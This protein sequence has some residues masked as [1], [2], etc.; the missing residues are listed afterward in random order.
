MD[1]LNP[2][3]IYH[4][5]CGSDSGWSDDHTFKSGIERYSSPFYLVIYGDTRT[6]TI[7]RVVVRNA[8]LK[9]LDSV[10]LILHCGDII[11][12]GAAQWQWNIFFTQM[13]TLFQSCPVMPTIGNHDL[14]D[15]NYLDQFSLPKN[16]GTERYYSFDYGN[17][18]IVSLYIPTPSSRNAWVIDDLTNANNNPAIRWKILFFHVPPYSAG[19]GYQ[20]QR[21]DIPPICDQFDIDVVY[22]GHTHNYE[23]TYLLYDNTVI[24]S[25]PDY[26]GDVD[27][28][29]Y[30]V[31]GGGMQ[32]I[33]GGVDDKGESQP[34]L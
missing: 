25:G 26:N 4:Y 32:S 21:E 7:E 5:R 9:H 18:H 16:S 17:L 12:N 22:C 3:T 11:A 28:T 8:I 29:V 33:P 24:D 6:D 27:G 20:N 13:E 10:D 15:K 19:Y 31:S 30:I 34:V 14:P 2:D 1:K 23:R